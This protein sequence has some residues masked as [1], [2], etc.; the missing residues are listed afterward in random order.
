MSDPIKPELTMRELLA[1]AAAQA[2]ERGLDVDAFMRGA[3]SAYVEARPGFREYLEEQQ[4]RAQL[5]ALRAAGH[6][7]KA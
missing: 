4:L 5:D 6:I 2:V 1:K 3:W 7:A